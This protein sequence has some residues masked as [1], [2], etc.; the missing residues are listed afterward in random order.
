M[1]LESPKF[2]KKNICEC[3]SS[4]IA[5]SFEEEKGKSGKHRGEGRREK[6]RKWVGET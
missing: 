1:H 5:K 6:K 3:C 2:V 4:F